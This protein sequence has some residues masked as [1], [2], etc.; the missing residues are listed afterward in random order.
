MTKK[1]SNILDQIGGTPL[2]PIGRLRTNE[3]V[4]ILAK[5]ECFNPGGSVKDR[6]ALRMIEEAEKKGAL[7]NEKIIL[8]ATSG[9][10]GRSLLY[11]Q[12]ACQIRGPLWMMILTSRQPWPPSLNSR[13]RLIGS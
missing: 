11:L 8:E 13:I 2:V 3:K 5:L 7:T 10:T 12:D 4:Q 6:P 9:N 1:Y